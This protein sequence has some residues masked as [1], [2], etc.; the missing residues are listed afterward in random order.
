MAEVFQF[1]DQNAVAAKMSQQQFEDVLKNLT[2][3]TDTPLYDIHQINKEDASG[4]IVLFNNELVRKNLTSP[5]GEF[6]VNS[7]FAAT[8]NAVNTIAT[9]AKS[10]DSADLGGS[11]STKNDSSGNVI[12]SNT[13]VT[14][15]G[16]SSSGGEVKFVENTSK[17]SKGQSQTS[18]GRM[19]K[20][21]INWTTDGGDITV[22]GD[23][24]MDLDNTETIQIEYNKWLMFISNSTGRFYPEHQFKITQDKLATALRANRTLYKNIINDTE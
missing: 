16:G 12:L 7:A 9:L 8:L 17:A 5:N 19:I 6:E 4:F 1:G 15:I 13:L 10:A 14:G 23:H 21:I 2:P 11:D 18:V 22:S 3:K 24:L 20:I